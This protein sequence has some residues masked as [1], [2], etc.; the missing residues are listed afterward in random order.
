L[1]LLGLPWLEGC[2]EMTGL[3]SPEN[4]AL[5]APLKKRTSQGKPL[6]FLIRYVSGEAS[7]VQDS[8]ALGAP[9]RDRICETLKITQRPLYSF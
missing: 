8:A 6:R 1:S 9:R 4:D 3:W 5:R 7:P 2:P